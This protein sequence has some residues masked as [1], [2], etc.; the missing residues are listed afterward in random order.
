MKWRGWLI[1]LGVIIGC[2][3]LQ[4]TF[5]PVLSVFGVKPDLLLLCSIMAA[6]KYEVYPAVGYGIFAGLLK[7]SLVPLDR[8][9][10]TVIFVLLNILVLR[11][12]R[13][14]SFDSRW[15]RFFLVFVLVNVNNAAFRLLGLFFG[16]GNTVSVAMFFKVSFLESLLTALCA[17]IFFPPDK[18][19]AVES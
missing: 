5:V 13:R 2:A 10:N 1:Y 14:V 6:V 17:Y 19:N 18:K 16:N 12:S 11:I 9:G 15:L 3:I 8:S 7:D 4:L